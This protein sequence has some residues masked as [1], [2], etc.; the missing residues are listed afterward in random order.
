MKRRSLL[1]ALFTLLASPAFSLGV[2]PALKATSDAIQGSAALLFFLISLGGQ[3]AW[4]PPDANGAYSL[5]TPLTPLQR[6]NNNLPAVQAAYLIAA[7]A[8]VKD[9]QDAGY[10]DYR[11]V[12]PEGEVS[13][14][15]LGATAGF[16]GWL[17]R[18]ASTVVSN[19]LDF[20]ADEGK[21]AFASYESAK[22]LSSD[23]RFVLGTQYVYTTANHH[24]WSID[25]AGLGGG[26][27]NDMGGDGKGRAYVATSKGLFRKTAG[28]ATWQKLAGFPDAFAGRVYFDRTGRMLVSN[29]NG[30]YLSADTGATFA[31]DTA[32]MGK[33][34]PT[35]FGEDRWG[36][37][38]AVVAPG[39]VYRSLGGTQPWTKLAGPLMSYLSG[40][41]EGYQAINGIVGD[42]LIAL[43][44]VY[45]VF[46][47][48]D[49][50][51]NWTA[52]TSLADDPYVTAYKGRDG[53]TYR[54]DAAGIR[55]LKPSDT[56][57]TRIFPD[58]G[59]LGHRP[60]FE[61]SAGRLYT[62]GDKV[63]GKNFQAPL[64]YNGPGPWAADTAGISGVTAFNSLLGN[65]GFWFVDH[66]GRQYL[67]DSWSGDPKLWT[68][69]T[70]SA[71]AMDTAGLPRTGIGQILSWGEDAGYVYMALSST[72]SGVFRRP[73]AGGAWER[74]SAGL[75]NVGVYSFASGPGG[76]LWAGAM[77]GLY[78]RESGVWHA[79]SLPDQSLAGKA[80]FTIAV[81]AKGRLYAAY[82]DFQGF[83]NKGLGVFA[84]DDNG[85]H[86]KLVG[87]QGVTA[88]TLTSA[89]DSV[90]AATYGLGLYVLDFGKPVVRV[91]P[92]G[93]PASADARFELRS[94]AFSGMKTLVLDLPVTLRVQADIVNAR[95]QRRMGV[96]DGIFSAGV[97]CL[98]FD[99]SKLPPGVYVLRLRAGSEAAGIKF[100]R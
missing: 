98:S 25:T 87:I 62:L 38:Y 33:K 10:Y 43:A 45:G 21:V 15:H 41:H 70:S 6:Y 55:R 60:L 23:G 29:S 51:D 28:D 18:S 65:A 12:T 34:S 96:A 90:Y 68:K 32:G 93:A 75:G 61:D 46:L 83:T 19:R 13:L 4:I 64:V 86:W 53:S 57:W 3:T 63:P 76:R 100:V 92:P 31:S 74:D 37:F 56:G 36:D 67:T 80:V 7:M 2:L 99:A 44:T 50:G 47:S 30:V 71:W 5:G 82:S 78:Y 8:V 88:R 35:Y 26:T 97:S 58:S 49:K 79:A 1:F 24:D 81:D 48:D 94:R 39:D 66:T 17:K 9:A 89:G 69:Q 85:A 52:V 54:S 84:T 27:I 59:W 42:S 14:F 22:K 40:Y 72:S 77:Q 16:G 73:I 91:S 95:G 11:E 20:V